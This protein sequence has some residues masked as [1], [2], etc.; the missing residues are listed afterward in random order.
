MRIEMV[1]KWI[2]QP[3]VQPK[4]LS[5][6]AKVPPGASWNVVRPDPAIQELRAQVQELRLQMEELRKQLKLISEHKKP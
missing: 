6:P 5:Q 4:V 1:P 3:I 2:Q